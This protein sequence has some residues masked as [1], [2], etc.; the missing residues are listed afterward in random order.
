MPY[1]PERIIQISVEPKSVV[2]DFITDLR[3]V[4]S[5]AWPFTLCVLLLKFIVSI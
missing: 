3:T 2:R 1:V 4:W 5:F